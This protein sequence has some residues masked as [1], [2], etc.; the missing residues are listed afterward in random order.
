MLRN[1]YLTS[2]LRCKYDSGRS[3]YIEVL[4]NRFGD[5]DIKFCITYN[6][7]V[8]KPFLEGGLKSDRGHF[9]DVIVW[10]NT[11]KNLRSLKGGTLGLALSRCKKSILCKFAM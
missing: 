9:Y 7:H 11:K 8:F 10:K 4:D 2:S 1:H 5:V 6:Q 3:K